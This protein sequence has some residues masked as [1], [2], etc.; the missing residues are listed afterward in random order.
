MKAKVTVF[1]HL[2][3][4]AYWIIK[5][6]WRLQIAILYSLMLLQCSVIHFSSLSCHS[7]D[8]ECVQ[9]NETKSKV[10]WL[11]WQ[12][13]GVTKSKLGAPK[14]SASFPIHFVTLKNCQM[15]ILPGIK[16]IFLT[17]QYH[18]VG[19]NLYKYFCNWAMLDIQNSRSNI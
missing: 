13:L 10:L 7:L 14:I 18:F 17:S 9:N 15:L 12:I 4:L 3:I 16:Y 1:D 2:F 6:A 19:C 11:Q 5:T 8:A